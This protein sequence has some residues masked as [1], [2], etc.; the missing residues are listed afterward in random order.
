MNAQETTKSKR[1][2]TGTIPARILIR[3][4]VHIV[5]RNTVAGF[6]I[7]AAIGA[8]FGTAIGNMA[9]SV[10]WGIAAGVAVGSILTFTQ[11]KS[12]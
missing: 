11:I 12:E 3:N 10:S 5:I 8:A 1:C 2:Q 6:T 7:G 4:A 9:E